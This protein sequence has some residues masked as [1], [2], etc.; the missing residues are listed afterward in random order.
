MGARPSE[1]SNRDSDGNRSGSDGPDDNGP[2]N[3]TSH[4]NGPDKHGNKGGGNE[5][6]DTIGQQI[7]AT[8]PES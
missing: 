5:R 8:R 7:T 1:H 4:N 6:W 2:S 3:D